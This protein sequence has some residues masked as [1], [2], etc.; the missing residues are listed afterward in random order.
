MKAKKYWILAGT[1]GICAGTL[2]GAKPWADEAAKSS[3]RNTSQPYTVADKEADTL[4]GLQ[5]VFV[6]LEEL[7]PEVSRYGLTKQALQN[8]IELRLRRNGI[9][10]LSEQEMSATPG[11]PNLYVNVNIGIFRPTPEQLDLVEREY[12]IF[13][14]MNVGGT[15]IEEMGLAS[16]A[17]D[18]QL[19]QAVLL[20]RDVNVVDPSA[21]TW[22]SSGV[23]SC[24][25]SKLKDVREIIE[26]YVGMF[27]NDYL[28]A[29]PKELEKPK[30]EQKQ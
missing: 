13:K 7:P 5:G 24:P 14:E 15:K 22:Q 20:V 4:V 18:V 21:I 29:N 26:D 11:Y 9:R 16:V 25:V 10:V 27:I 6:L 3:V 23:V 17:I 1:L 19:T 2:L 12:P 8:D 28:S 30:G